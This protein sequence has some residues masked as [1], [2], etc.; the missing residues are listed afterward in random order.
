MFM[1]PEE[2]KSLEPHDAGALGMST[3]ELW[4]KVSN[5]LHGEDRSRDSSGT[6]GPDIMASVRRNGVREP[7]EIGEEYQNT[8]TSHLYDGHH[9]TQAAEEAGQAYVPVTYRW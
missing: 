3:P 9:R 7:V 8:G 1:P 4:D 2:L 5:E 6:R